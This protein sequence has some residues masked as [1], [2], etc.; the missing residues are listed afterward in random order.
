MC[1]GFE[2]QQFEVQQFEVLEFMLRPTRPQPLRASPQRSPPQRRPARKFVPRVLASLNP[3]ELPDYRPVG[4]LNQIYQLDRNQGLYLLEFTIDGRLRGYSGSSDDLMR[5]LQAH[6][7]CARVM[8]IEPGTILVYVATSP[9]ITAWRSREQ[10]LHQLM[11]DKAPD[12]LTNQRLELEC[13]D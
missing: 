11:R 7:L 9:R 2:V 4:R 12:V 3:D 6:R 5:R 10:A 1:Q 13:G 8:G